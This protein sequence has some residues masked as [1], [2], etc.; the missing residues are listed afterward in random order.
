MKVC[1]DITLEGGESYSM[2][3]KQLE[4]PIVAQVVMFYRH[5]G[6]VQAFT[7]GGE[8]MGYTLQ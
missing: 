2:G 3:S 5:Q 7:G 1:R 4:L 6:R 8:A